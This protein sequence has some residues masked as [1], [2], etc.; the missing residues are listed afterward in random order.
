MYQSEADEEEP[1]V[2]HS[3]APA[4]RRPPLALNTSA[5]SAT[6]DVTLVSEELVGYES[7]TTAMV[8]ENF[9]SVEIV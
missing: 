7:Y 2:M 9:G 5:F 6:S 1:A 8:S 3:I 4:A